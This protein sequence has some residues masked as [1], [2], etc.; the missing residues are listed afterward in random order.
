[1]GDNHGL[2]YVL[3]PPL[4]R[5]IDAVQVPTRL[6]R[7]TVVS[8]F[9]LPPGSLEISDPFV[10]L[11][12]V[13]LQLIVLKHEQRLRMILLSMLCSIIQQSS[14][15]VDRI[16]HFFCFKFVIKTL[17][18]MINWDMLVPECLVCFEVC[19][20]GNCSTNETHRL[21][22]RQFSPRL[23]GLKW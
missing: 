16:L 14:L 13:E 2:G 17:A 1:M 23:N 10:K 9:K 19:I 6:L 22:Q 8:C 20:L 3:K 5:S 12:Y 15:F 7:V 21:D 4:L 18:L 11:S